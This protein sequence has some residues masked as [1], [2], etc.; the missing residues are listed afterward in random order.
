[1]GAGRSGS[2]ILGVTLGNCANI[3]YAGELDKWLLMSGVSMHERAGVS[4]NGGWDGPP[5]LWS[6]VREDVAAPADLF[7]REARRCIEHSSALF[8]LDK[9]RARR[10]LRGRYRRVTEDLYRAIAR[11][12]GASCIVDSSHFPLRARQLQSLGGIELYLLFL[13]RDPRSVVASWDRPGLPEPRF[14]MLATNAYLW[15]T[16][17]LSVFVFLSHPR[18]R[19]LFIRYEDFIANPEVIL[20]DILDRTGSSAAIPDLTSLSTGAPYHGNRLIF[21]DVVSLEREGAIA[22]RSSWITTLLQLPWAIVLPFLR[23]SVGA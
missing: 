12:A 1:M 20:R 16:H 17:L 2:T 3:F 4:T 7:G 10:R 9:W 18:E 19:R 23:P 22:S 21:S 14:S 13:V 5:E 11:R 6:L 15:L 8:R